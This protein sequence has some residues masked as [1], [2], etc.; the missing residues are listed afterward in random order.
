MSARL[1]ETLDTAAARARERAT[2]LR[3]HG[4]GA[5]MTEYHLG[6]AAAFE[7]MAALLRST[8]GEQAARLAELDTLP[9]FLGGPQHTEPGLAESP[10]GRDDAAN[11]IAPALGAVRRLAL[12]AAQH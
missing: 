11:G 5:A 7:Q 12:R 9:A 3:R 2:F 4:E 6:R 1:A 10:Q 8:G